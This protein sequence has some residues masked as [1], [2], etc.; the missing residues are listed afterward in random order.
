ML[1]EPEQD[2]VQDDGEDGEVHEDESWAVSVEEDEDGNIGEH[3]DVAEGNK[4]RLDC[5]WNFS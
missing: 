5:G 4:Q 2:E 3:E 1:M